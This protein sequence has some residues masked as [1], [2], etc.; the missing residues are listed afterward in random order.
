MRLAPAMKRSWWAWIAASE[1]LRLIARLSP[2][3]SHRVC[4]NRAYIIA[5]EGFRPTVSSNWAFTLNSGPNSGS[6][7]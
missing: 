4:T 1:R 7:V 2:S 5:F 6:R 3:A